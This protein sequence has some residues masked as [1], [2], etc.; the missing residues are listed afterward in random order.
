MC[1]VQDCQR[2]V[3]A[4]G[5]CH[6]HYDAKR[7]ET[8]PPC[9][10]DGCDSPVKSR[11]MCSIHYRRDLATRSDFCT[12]EGC[13]NRTHANGLCTT[14]HTRVRRHG[15]LNRVRP[16]TFSGTD[17]QYEEQY[18]RA[19]SRSLKRK[20]GI[21]LQD[22][23]KMH[24]ERNGKCDICNREETSTEKSTGNI[25]RL[26]VDHCHNTEKVRGLLCATC[27]TALGKFRDSK[28]TLLKAIEYL[29]K[30]S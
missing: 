26:A 22:Y 18:R 15:S 10:V 3:F 8:A 4:L 7:L 6:I 2:K 14:H 24:E 16:N 12:V 9:S 1:S 29:D 17:K 23:E 5:M 11:N 21:T 27:N 25:R 28:D 20:Y 13:K 19:A 30:F